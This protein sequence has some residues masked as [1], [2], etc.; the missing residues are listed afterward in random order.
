MSCYGGYLLFLTGDL[1]WY[2]LPVQLTCVPY[3]NDHR[4][5]AV[6]CHHT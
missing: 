3:S 2:N 4:H 1:H 6:N 5:L